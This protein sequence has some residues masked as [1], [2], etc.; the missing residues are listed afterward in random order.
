[1]HVYKFGGASVKDAASVRNVGTILGQWPSAGAPLLVVVSAMGK[2][3]DALESLLRADPASFQAGIQS[4]KEFH[5]RILDELFGDSRHPAFK[6]LDTLFSQLIETFEKH[7][8]AGEDYLYDQT[9]CFGEFFSTSIVH[10]YLEHTGKPFHWIDARK[11]IQTDDRHR[12]ARINWKATGE[13]VR[14]GLPPLLVERPVL[15]QGFI[16]S[17]EGSTTT[18]GREGSDFTASVFASLL[19]ADGLTFWKDVPGILNADPRRFSD[20]TLFSELTYDDAIEMTYYGARVLHPRTVKPLQN[21]GIPLHVRSFLEPTKPGTRISPDARSRDDIPVII[22]QKNQSVISLTL[23][24]HSF[25]AENSLYDIFKS[26]SELRI[27]L[28]MMRNS[29]LSFAVCVDH[30]GGKIESF[31]REMDRN[32]HTV[33]TTGMELIT[34]RHYNQDVT[35][36]LLRNRELHLEQRTEKTVQFAVRSRE[37]D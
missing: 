19:D 6:R 18:L 8:E 4:I 21:A 17:F 23:R 32:F 35:E 13:L 31:R 10:E 3:T 1:M 26:L 5:F 34:I 36:R 33:L 30:H 11:F 15:T 22:V 27:K 14:R 24:D 20:T 2:T 29:A 28:N 7:K 9:I 16:G 37:A 12:E 25:I